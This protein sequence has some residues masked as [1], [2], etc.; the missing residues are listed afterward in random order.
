MKLFIILSKT[1]KPEDYNKPFS[2]V[3]DNTYALRFLKNLQDNPN[4]CTGCG[5]KCTH[6]RR[7]YHLDKTSDIAGILKLPAA[8]PFYVDNPLKYFPE[9][10]PRHDVVVAIN[11][12]EDILLTLPEIINKSGAKAIII[13]SEHPDWV[14]KWIRLEIKRKC[15]R[16]KMEFAFPKPFCSLDEKEETPTI[17]KFINHFKIG[18][19][20]VTATI[21]DGIIK[22]IKVL[23]SAPCGDTYFVAHNLINEKLDENIDR[24]I[25]KYWHSYP[26][27]A[28]MKMDYEIGDTI[29]HI[30][31]YIHY[32]AFN[33]AFLKARSD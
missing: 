20:K 24:K 5:D 14:S 21:K 3:F 7:V 23:V 15:D 26:C 16:L 9:K 28:S 25:G 2:S 19:P 22:K 8:L 12:H 31:G 6:C 18:K 27:V 11:V 33:E 13:P 1:P 10:L 32:N 4:L 17:N 29:L 30:G